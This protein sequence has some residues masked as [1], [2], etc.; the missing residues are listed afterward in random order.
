MKCE[1]LQRCLYDQDDLEEEEEEEEED[2]LDTGE[3]PFLPSAMLGQVAKFSKDGS[4]ASVAMSFPENGLKL[5]TI[6][7]VRTPYESQSDSDVEDDGRPPA[8][9]SRM[10][11]VPPLSPLLDLKLLPWT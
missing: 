3:E 1:V 8:K 5:E 10:T 7:R 4:L 11:P 9:R 6:K 2:L